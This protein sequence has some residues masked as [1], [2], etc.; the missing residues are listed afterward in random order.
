MGTDA[1]DPGTILQALADPTRRTVLDQLRNGPLPVNR[2]ADGLPVSRPAV[3][4]HLKVLLD[5]GLVSM[6]QQGTRNLYAL[7]NGGAQPLTDWLGALSSVGGAAREFK[8]LRK[9]VVVRLTPAETWQL[10]CN[11]LSLWWPVSV[12]SRSAQEAGA[13]PMMVELDARPGGVMR[14]ILFDGTDRVWGHVRDAQDGQHLTLDWR[15]GESPSVVEVTVQPESGGA[16]LI[17]TEDQDTPENHAIWDL[18][19]TERFAAA[20]ASSLSNF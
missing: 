11:D 3:S 17:L 18:V 2:I 19:I 12:V 8:G 9:E 13:L 10:F 6:D 15:F 5:A 7:K 20:A 4:Q 16:R 14:E 1:Q